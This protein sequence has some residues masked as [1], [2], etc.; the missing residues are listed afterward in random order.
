M[1]IVSTSFKMIKSQKDLQNVATTSCDPMQMSKDSSKPF[2]ALKQCAYI[3]YIPVITRALLVLNSS[4]WYMWII[5]ITPWTLFLQSAHALGH[6]FFPQ[7]SLYILFA[8]TYSILVVL[9]F[10]W[11]GSC[12]TNVASPCFLDELWWARTWRESRM[13][14][15][16]DIFTGDKLSSII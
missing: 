13:M 2:I 4:T 6:S 10:F 15:I 8:H 3:K 5:T 14:D 9:L 12:E 11:E 16:E 7:F 1:S